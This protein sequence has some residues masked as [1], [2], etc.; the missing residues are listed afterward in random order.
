M[1]QI[2]RCCGSGVRPAAKAP[3]GPLT[4][5]PPYPVG[6]ALEKAKKRPKTKKEVT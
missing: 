2:W 1:A 3:I 5:E 6:A 4:W